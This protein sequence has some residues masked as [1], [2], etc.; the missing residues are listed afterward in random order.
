MTT[1]KSPNLQSQSRRFRAV[2]SV[3]PVQSKFEGLK[4]RSSDNIVSVGR[5][6]A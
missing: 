2:N 4:T 1:E 5:L 3:V 6:Q